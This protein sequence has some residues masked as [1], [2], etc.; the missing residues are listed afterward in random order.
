M[1]LFFLPGLLADQKETDS[2]NQLAGI[3]EINDSLEKVGGTI[4]INSQPGHGTH[5]RIKLLLT[6]S[7]I[8]SQIVKLGEERSRS[9]R[10]T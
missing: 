4:D 1:R 2:F 7:I 10:Q 3:D 6:L 5:V 8:P 9:P